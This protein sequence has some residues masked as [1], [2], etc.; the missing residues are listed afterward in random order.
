MNQR[1]LTVSPT[2]QDCYRSISSALAAARDGSII[3]VLPGAYAETIRL[4]WS[5]T[6]VAEQGRGSVTIAPG[7]GSAVVMATDTA[8]LSGLTLGSTN[9]QSATVE[10]AVGRLRLNDC[11]L[12][13]A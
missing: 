3:N 6:V 7:A 9:P 10:V 4:T 11:R 2:Q 5:C 13:A 8:V 12:A 1:V